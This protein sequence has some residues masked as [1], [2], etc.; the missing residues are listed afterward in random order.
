MPARRP[1]PRGE[2]LHER[3][4]E[5][6]TKRRNWLHQADLSTHSRSGHLPRKPRSGIRG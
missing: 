6:G 2:P 1:A 5:G 3:R 4:G